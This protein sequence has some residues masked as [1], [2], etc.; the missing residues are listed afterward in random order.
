M[1][2][3]IAAD[4]RLSDAAHGG[5]ERRE[6]EELS[7][8]L[9]IA[10][11]CRPIAKGPGH[12]LFLEGSRSL[13][14]VFI[15]S[16]TGD[17]LSRVANGDWVPACMLRLGNA[18]VK[19]LGYTPRNPGWMLDHAPVLPRPAV[20]DR[21]RTR[22]SGVAPLSQHRDGGAHEQDRQE[23]LQWSARDTGRHAAAKEDTGDRTNQEFAGQSHIYI[24]HEQQVCQG[25]RSHQ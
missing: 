25:C 1:G 21:G 16:G 3:G 8:A 2:G 12:T 6:G 15:L 5:P 24:L 14:A 18:V 19:M 23:R 4:P 10:C 20:R 22:G 11:S 7:L 13:L 17:L 9:D